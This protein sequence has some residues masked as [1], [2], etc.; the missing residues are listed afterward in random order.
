MKMKK[1]RLKEGVGPQF[2]YVDPPLS[3]SAKLA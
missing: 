1:S 2:Y 3:S